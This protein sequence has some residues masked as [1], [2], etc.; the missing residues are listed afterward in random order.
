VPEVYEP[1]TLDQIEA[2]ITVIKEDI[3]QVRIY[4]TRARKRLQQAYDGGDN[5]T[6]PRNEWLKQFNGERKENWDARQK[7]LRAGLNPCRLIPDKI[8]AHMTNGTITIT[9]DDP[10]EQEIVDDIRKANKWDEVL[11]RDVERDCSVYGTI[12]VSPFWNVPQGRIDY[13]WADVDTYYPIL[14][15]KDNREMDAFMVAR[16]ESSFEG[17]YITYQECIDIWTPV[18]RGRF[19]KGVSGS[20]V[21]LLRHH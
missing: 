7:Q 14:S 19:G 11:R 20:K 18:E 10:K 3:D 17:K 2:S 6:D 4:D 5:L 16:P 12:A 13:W 21:G 1:L 15:G 8:T 9:S